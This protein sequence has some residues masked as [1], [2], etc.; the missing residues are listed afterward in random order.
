MGESIWLYLKLK[1]TKHFIAVTVPLSCLIQ[2]VGNIKD[3]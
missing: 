1:K 2:N 3:C